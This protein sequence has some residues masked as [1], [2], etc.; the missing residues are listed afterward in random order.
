MYLSQ[1]LGVKKNRWTLGKIT[2]K[3]VDCLVCHVCLSIILF[4]DEKLAR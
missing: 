4:K 1:S 3:K 2:G